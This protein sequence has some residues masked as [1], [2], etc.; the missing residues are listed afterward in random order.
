MPKRKSLLQKNWLRDIQNIDWKDVVDF[1]SNFVDPMMRNGEQFAREIQ[2]NPYIKVDNQSLSSDNIAQALENT[3]NTETNTQNI[4]RQIINPKQSAQ[5]ITQTQ[6]NF[7]PIKQTYQYQPSQNNASNYGVTGYS[8]QTTFPFYDDFTIN[9]IF[10]KTI[11]NKDI[12][13]IN[14]M[15]SM[16]RKVRN[17]D[18]YII[19]FTLSALMGAGLTNYVQSAEK[20]RKE[21]ESEWNDPQ[22][23]RWQNQRNINNYYDKYMPFYKDIYFY[24]S[25]RKRDPLPGFKE[26]PYSGDQKYMDAFTGD[27]AILFRAIELLGLNPENFQP[28]HSRVEDANLNFKNNKNAPIYGAIVE[29]LFP[30]RPDK[31]ITRMSYA[32]PYPSKNSSTNKRLKKSALKKNWFRD[33]ENINWKDVFEFISNMLPDKKNLN[34]FATIEDALKESYKQSSKSNKFIANSKTNI[35]DLNNYVT[36]ALDKIDDKV[37]SWTLPSLL[38]AGLV[39]AYIYNN[40]PQ[41]LEIPEEP[42]HSHKYDYLHDHY[43]NVAQGKKILEQSK[44][45]PQTLNDYSTVTMP[46]TIN[47]TLKNKIRNSVQGLTITSFGPEFHGEAKEVSA[48]PMPSVNS[49]LQKKEKNNT[50]YKHAEGKP[51]LN[52]YAIPYKDKFKK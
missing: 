17:N 1:I 19:P 8:K 11:S 4:I 42:E 29:E 50:F 25:N 30:T 47:N 26:D 49:M 34:S 16:Y 14:D 20:E 18:K 41:P 35:N 22:V 45:F 31:S 15:V 28:I 3:Y 33:V 39:T 6:N 38:G 52:K 40:Q 5:S 44:F 32:N 43:A 12:Q 21:N 36:N 2:K 27:K 48:K 46:E 37:G 23:T 7:T 9:D 24:P 13:D 10:P 51:H